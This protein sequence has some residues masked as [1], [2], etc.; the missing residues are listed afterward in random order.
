MNRENNDQV[1]RLIR[2]DGVAVVIM[3]EKEFSNTFTHRFI[4]GM[5]AV[6]ETIAGSPEIKAVV[7][8]GFDNYF[9]CGGTKEELLSLQEGMGKEAGQGQVKFTDA[10]FHDLFIRC[11][12]PVIAAMQGHALGAGFVLGCTADIIIMAEQSIYAANFMKYGFTPGFGATYIV[13]LKLGTALG[14]EMLWTAKNYYGHQ[15]RERGAPVRIVPR[16]Q[17]IPTA[18]E[19]AGGLAEKPLVTLKMLKKHLSNPVQV[20]LQKIIEAEIE[21]HRVTFPQP[22]VR[23]MIERLFGS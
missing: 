6:F 16:Q 10:G 23:Q 22:E 4:K 19:I 12:V 2:Q 13:P 15:L 7:V 1:I 18:L 5:L 17:V 14:N 20:E 21:L 11:E 9:C 3:E 8:H